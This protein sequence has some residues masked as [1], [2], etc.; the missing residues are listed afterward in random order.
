VGG[1]TP[2]VK[3]K[4]AITGL[5]LI[6]II[7]ACFLFL[8]CMGVIAST[9]SATAKTYFQGQ[10]R[11]ELQ[12]TMRT[13]LDIMSSE[14]REVH[15]PSATNPSASGGNITFEKYD[16]MKQQNL[17]VTYSLVQTVTDPDNGEIHRDDGHSHV[18]IGK[19]ISSLDFVYDDVNGIVNINISAL[20]PTTRGPITYTTAVTL[21]TGTA[22]NVD[23][24]ATQ[25]TGKPDHSGASNIW[26]IAP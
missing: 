24:L 3:R 20:N 9:F 4:Y 26:E 1:G 5:T 8:L 13:C 25:S 2:A 22:A 10:K 12:H 23:L 16:N 19:G 15:L 7:L 18:I 11:L 14:I 17:T 6:E 21:R